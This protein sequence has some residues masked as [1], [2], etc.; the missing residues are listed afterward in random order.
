MAQCLVANGFSLRYFDRKNLGELDFVIQKGNSAVALEIKSGK[1]YHRHA[2][3]DNI[4]SN[5]EWKLPEGLVFCTGNIEKSDKITYLPLYMI[6]F[7][8]QDKL[9]ESLVVEVEVP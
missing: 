9:P 3:L 6:Q 2:A 8:K 1:D 5:K 4:L 7:L